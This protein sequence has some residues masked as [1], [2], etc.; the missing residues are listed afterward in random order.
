M[1]ALDRPSAPAAAPRASGALY[2]P[3]ALALLVVL[4]AAKVLAFQ[5][6]HGQPVDFD[7]FHVVGRM[8]LAGHA[9]D[10]YHAAT[11]LRAESQASGGEAAFLPFT[12]PPQ[13]ALLMAP[14]AGL[15]MGWAYALFIGA[16]L[17]AYLAVLKRVAGEDFATVLLATLPSLAVGLACGQN[18]FLTGAL[19]GLA[20]LGLVAGRASAGLSLGLMILKPH[21]AV[22]LAVRTLAGR[23]WATAAV[24][25][26]VVAGSSALATLVLGPAIWREFAVSAGEAKAFLHAGLYPLFRMVSVY[27]SLRTLGVGEGWALGLQGLAAAAAL[28]GVVRLALDAEASPR[29]QAGFAVVSAV[30][31]SPYAYDYDLALSGIGLALLLPELRRRAFKGELAAILALLAFAGLYGLAKAGLMQ[32]MGRLLDP[33]HPPL[34]PSG[35]AVAGAVLLIWRALRRE[36]LRSASA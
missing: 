11:L 22:T 15:P 12:Y 3:A 19:V 36:P 23:S 5:G 31:V 7:C 6:P 32:V 24:A 27:S 34:A 28:A 9:G 8:V 25:V 30:V 2:A 14:F 18:G 26:A 10:A 20:S 13:F 1:A 16:T 17:L 33:A 35:L 21:L 4:Y 29:V